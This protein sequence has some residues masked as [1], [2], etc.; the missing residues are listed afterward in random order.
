MVARMADISKEIADFRNAVYGKDVRGSMISLAEKV[1]AEAAKAQS[2]AENVVSRANAGEF[3]GAQGPPGPQ[4]PKGD[5][6]DGGGASVTTGQAVV[7]NFYC[8]ATNSTLSFAKIGNVVWV[9]GSVTVLSD[10]NAMSIANGLPRALSSGEPYSGAI[11]GISG[12][13][14]TLSTLNGYVNSSGYLVVK[15]RG[16]SEPFRITGTYLT[17]S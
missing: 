12:D 1:N 5:P 17:S 2:D 6:G 14:D 8:D 11:V 15:S 13:G 7:D 16:G 10:G 3:N 9:F 4:G